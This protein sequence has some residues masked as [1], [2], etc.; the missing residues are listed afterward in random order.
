MIFEALNKEGKMAN[1]KFIIVDGASLWHMM[2]IL[3][4][5]KYNFKELQSI[6]TKEVGFSAHCYGRPVYVL[7]K[8]TSMAKVVAA[9]GFEAVVTE[10]GANADDQE[11]IRRLTQLNQDEVSEVVLVS[12]D[13]D[14]V[15]ILKN[16]M[17]LG[18]RIT[19]VATG[20]PSDWNED[21]PMLSSA[22]AE[23]FSSG[24]AFVELADYKDR[25]MIEPFED[26]R[27]QKKE[28]APLLRI[29]RVSMKLMLENEDIPD[30]TKVVSAILKC[31]PRSTSTIRVEK[32]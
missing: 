13:G 28:V 3:G 12:A 5:G 9:N 22:Y 2:R 1:A 18:T 4:V 31:Y 17:G 10:G 23:L 16:K 14:Y 19:V 21:R 29:V 30:V 24:A 8:A 7:G 15:D 20:R 6:L 11:I 27:P 32:Q 25:L 26:R